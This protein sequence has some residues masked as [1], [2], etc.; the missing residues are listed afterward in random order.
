MDI[1]IGVVYNVFDGEELLEGSIRSI[2]EKVDFIVILFQTVSNFGN[3]YE[4]SKIESEKLLEMGLVDEIRQYS[5]TIQY[6]ENGS[7][8]WES[9]C[10]NE[11][12]KR[13][14]RW[15]F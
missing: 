1:K 7:V 4:Q 13:N 10:D 5:P 9:G 12:A 8:F 6:M 14:F 15:R 11:M 2:R 3:Q